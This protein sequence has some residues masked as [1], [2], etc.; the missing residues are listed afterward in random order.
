MSNKRVN[1]RG[2][3]TIIATLLLILLTIVLIGILW[4]IIRNVTSSASE[5]IN[6]GGITLDLKIQNANIGQNNLSVT[7]QRQSGAGSLTGI[8]FI[9]YDGK[10]YET[11]K[12]NATLD[13]YQGKQF[14]LPIGQ[15]NISDIKTVSVAPLYLSSSGTEQ[16]G[17]ITD[18]F[19][20]GVSGSSQ[21]GGFC[22]DGTCNGGESS[23]SCS[24]DCPVSGP[25]CGN[26][27]LESGEQCD[28][29]NIVNGDGCSSTC[30]DEI[31]GAVC[32]NFICEIGETTTSCPADCP[33][34]TCT[35]TTC[36]LAGYQCGTASDG[37]GGTLNCPSCGGNSFCDA[38][39]ICEQFQMVN[40]G[41]I[42]S[43]WPSGSALYFDSNDLPKSQSE[44]I[45]YNDG[46]HYVRFP[47]KPAITCTRIALAD[48]ISENSRSYIELYN[49][50]NIAAGDNY[51][52]WNAQQGCLND[53]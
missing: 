24:A 35:P 16:V 41:S 13:I 39:H 25:V 5:G 29:G 46:L 38:N 14:I 18:T 34:Q 6:L 42:L 45:P 44:L 47:N 40:N 2:I 26:H 17:R 11:I 50:A 36:Q 32:G 8:N 10:N 49:V 21:Q 33:S 23:S 27:I 22:G 3:S 48:Y 31:P 7:V 1:R 52:I 30:Q 43:V 19:N 12:Q 51:R 9:L 4:V 28:D 53:A 15:I 20:F 37:C